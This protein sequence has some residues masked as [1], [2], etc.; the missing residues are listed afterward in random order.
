MLILGLGC[1]FA[2]GCHSSDPWANPMRVAYA[3]LA[4]PARQSQGQPIKVLVMAS[5]DGYGTKTLQPD[6]VREALAQC[7]VIVTGD[8]APRM[9]QYLEKLGPVSVP[10]VVARTSATGSML[11]HGPSL[12]DLHKDGRFETKFFLAE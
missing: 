7:D 1:V 12:L 8:E 9:S 3:E 11:I 10:I 5:F 2:V 4:A 6:Q